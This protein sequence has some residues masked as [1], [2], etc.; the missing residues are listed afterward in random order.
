MSQRLAVHWD[1]SEPTCSGLAAVLIQELP[2][3][4]S[5]HRP[6]G[7]EGDG[8]VPL[9]PHYR[10]L[11][12]PLGGP[13]GAGPPLLGPNPGPPGPQPPR[14]L[15]PDG[16]YP[17]SSL[18]GG[19]PAERESER[20]RASLNPANANNG[21]A[22]SCGEDHRKQRWVFNFSRDDGPH[23]SPPSLHGG[24][25]SRRSPVPGPSCHGRFLGGRDAMSMPCIDE[26]RS[27]PAEEAPSCIC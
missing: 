19:R 16:V 7:R 3:P 2:G 9:L 20:E 6:A 5:V 26:G 8:R 13:L 25:S 18:C 4:G 24:S 12:P 14:P 17:P 22:A 21:C 11:M 23:L 10:P 27:R 15:R 1:Q